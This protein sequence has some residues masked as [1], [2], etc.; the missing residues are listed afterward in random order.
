M[1]ETTLRR[2]A[3]RSRQTIIDAAE[4]LFA[5]LG[6]EAVSMERIGRAAGLSR[7]APG[8]FFGSKVALYRAVL[9]RMF[10]ATEQLVAETN[11]QLTA[12]ADGDLD[13]A[14]EIVVENLLEFLYERPT[15]LTLV[16]R[17]ALRRTGLMEGTRAHLTLLRTTLTIAEKLDWTS[18]A[19]NPQ[20]LLLTLL[21]LCWFPLANPPL[22]RDLGGQLDRTFVEARKRHVVALLKAG[23]KNGRR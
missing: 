6:Y 8:Y 19:T 12:V 10:E 22:I 17:E 1:D 21:G 3:E 15:F 13:G 2:D 23:L 4:R 7:G 16:Q 5:D 20:Q 18:V 9:Q 14:L 11:R